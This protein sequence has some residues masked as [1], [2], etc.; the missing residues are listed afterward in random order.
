MAKPVLAGAPVT[1]CQAPGAMH[2]WVWT[3]CVQLS[4]E[5]LY[6]HMF[7][8]RS[9]GKNFENPEGMK[10]MEPERAR[11]LNIESGK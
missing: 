4:A 9:V 3:N 8:E 2:Q 10:K 11:S 6:V 7:S 1:R 5:N